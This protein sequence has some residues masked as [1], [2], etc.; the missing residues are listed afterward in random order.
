M[1]FRL[2]IVWLCGYSPLKGKLDMLLFFISSWLFVG[3]REGKEENSF[4]LLIFQV[5][6]FQSVDPFLLPIILII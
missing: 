2:L 5:T 4:F 1:Q 3:I 6:F